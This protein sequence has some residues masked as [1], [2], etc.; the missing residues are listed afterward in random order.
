MDEKVRKQTNQSALSGLDITLLSKCFASRMT[1]WCCGTCLKASEF[2]LCSEHVIAIAITFAHHS[3]N[4]TLLQPL[5]LFSNRHHGPPSLRCRSLLHNRIRC[6]GYSRLP[7]LV[8]GWLALL[9]QRRKSFRFLESKHRANRGLASTQSNFG[10]QE[11]CQ[12]VCVDK[13]RNKDGAAC[14]AGGKYSNVGGITVQFRE[15]CQ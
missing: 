6:S 8:P 11:N 4:P 10:P 7:V 15:P 3:Q 14:N 5:P 1:G 12:D 13:K 9:R 2:H